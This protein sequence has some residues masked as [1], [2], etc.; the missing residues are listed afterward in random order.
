LEKTF[1][2]EF[3]LTKKSGNAWHGRKSHRKMRPPSTGGTKDVKRA[4]K[5][6]T[7]RKSK[8]KS[9]Q[10]LTQEMLSPVSD[11]V[12]GCES[13]KLNPKDA[14]KELVFTTTDIFNAMFGLP[15]DKTATYN[16]VEVKSQIDTELID[17]QH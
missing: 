3:G 8:P 2:E 10:I 6:E 15:T 11:S 17:H 12:V 7:Q 9:D 4:C 16:S 5:R 13:S 1:L 14:D